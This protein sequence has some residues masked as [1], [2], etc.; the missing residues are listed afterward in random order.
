MALITSAINAK[1]YC[2]GPKISAIKFLDITLKNWYYV[3]LF[4]LIKVI[5]QIRFTDRIENRFR[6]VVDQSCNVD[7][8]DQRILW[9]IQ[10][11]HVLGPLHQLLCHRI[12]VSVITISDVLLRQRIVGICGPLVSEMNRFDEC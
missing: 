8:R 12:V 5:S 11:R 10:R 7:G 4:Y 9:R 1:N 3:N 2:W 6:S